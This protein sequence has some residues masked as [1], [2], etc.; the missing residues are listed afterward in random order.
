MSDA[1]QLLERLEAAG[2]LVYGFMS[3]TPQLFWPLLGRRAGREV[4][5]KHENHLP[6]GSFKLRGALT[7]L[8][9]LQQEA[10]H[11]RTIVASAIGNHG[12]GVALAAACFGLRSII[13]AD[14]N[15]SAEKTIALR[16]FG[17]EVVVAGENGQEA[18]E[19]ALMIAEER[20]AYFAPVFHP[21]L[22]GGAASWAL[23]LFK[24][25]PDIETLYVPLGHGSAVAGAIAAR[26]AL[27]LD[28]KI[29]GVVAEGAPAFADSVWA[30]RLMTTNGAFT[31]A[32]GLDCCK[33]DEQA[34]KL[35]TQGI[36]RILRVTDDMI[37][38]AIGHYYNDC[39]NIADGAGAASL[40]GLLDD[41]IDG[42]KSAVLLSGANIETPLFLSALGR[43]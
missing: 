37:V 40:A 2:T 24:S 1:S 12:H 30:R 20:N 18:E 14:M 16:S 5:V 11:V 32:D 41:E 9:Q 8:H 23:E 35:V 27:E 3:P 15:I 17:A 19:N 13:V 26:D 38:A 33:P 10:P 6:G 31:V 29:V 43:N 22:I 34:L 7:Y 4:W 39:R 42:G 36:D 25:V 28:A 21:W